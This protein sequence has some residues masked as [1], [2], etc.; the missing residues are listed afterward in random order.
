MFVGDG[1]T[2]AKELADNKEYFIPIH[3]G[4]GNNSVVIGNT[5]SQALGDNSY[6]AGGEV[7]AGTRGY[8]WE[9]IDLENRKIYLCQNQVVTTPVI[10]AGASYSFT[11]DYAIGDKLAIVNNNKYFPEAVITSIENNIITYE[12]DIGFTQI[13]AVDTDT[14]D[15]DDY[16]IYV[17]AKPA[18]EADIAPE[19]R[20]SKEIKRNA[21]AEGYLSNAQGNASHAEGTFSTAYGDHAHSEGYNTQAAWAAHS[22]GYTTHAKGFYSH[23]EGRQTETANGAE[24][25]H[26][27]G[28]AVK[29]SGYAAHGEGIGK[30]TGSTI[31]DYSEA[32]GRGSHVE[33]IYNKALASAAHVEGTNNVGSGP[34]SH[35][36]GA[37][38]TN[39]G[40]TTHVE[41][42]ENTVSTNQAHAEGKGNTLSGDAHYSHVEGQNNDITARIA[43]A[44]GYDNTISGQKAH[45]EG[46]S[47]TVSGV[48]AH[49]EGK[50]NSTVASY[51][52]VEGSSNKIEAGKIGSTNSHVEGES[53]TLTGGLASHI[54]GKNNKII[55]RTGE[56]GY[57]GSQCHI[58]G[59]GNTIE[60]DASTE[61][62]VEGRGNKAAAAQAHA[63]GKD[64]I[65][66]GAQSHAGGLGTRA[67]TTAQTAIGKYNIIDED[68]L[69]IVGKGSSNENRS[70][71][72]IIDKNGNAWFNGEV[73]VGGDGL[74]ETGCTPLVKS[75]E[76]EMYAKK[77][78]NTD[79]ANYDTIY[80]A[81]AYTDKR[82]Q[83]ELQGVDHSD[84]LTIAYGEGSVVDGEN[85]RAA[86]Y[87]ATA[88]GENTQAEG[89]H[90]YAGCRG[91]YWKAIDLDNKKI[92][93][94][95][96]QTTPLI[97][98]SIVIINDDLDIIG[99]SDD[100][101]SF[102]VTYYDDGSNKPLNNPSIINIAGIAYVI[103][104]E[105]LSSS[106]ISFSN[107]SATLSY[108]GY[109]ESTHCHS[110]TANMNF[111]TLSGSTGYIESVVGCYGDLVDEVPSTDYTDT[112][113][114]PDYVIGDEIAI[115]NNNKYFPG[116]TISAIEN[117]VITYDGEI[118]FDKINEVDSEN[119]DIDDYCIYVIAKPAPEEDIEPANRIC[120]SVKRDSHAEGCLSNAQGNASHAEGSATVAYGDH[121][122]AE[123]HDTRAAW[124]A[125][126]EGSGT[127][128]SGFRSHA[129]GTDT[130][131]S[132]PSSHAEGT[133]SQ[134]TNYHAHAE[135]LRTVASG[136]EAHSEGKQTTASG[137]GA[138]SEGYAT[139]AKGTYSHAE[140][141][142]T[143]ALADRT[144]SEG[145]MTIA[146]ADQSH[147][148]GLRSETAGSGAHAEGVD[149][150]YAVGRGSHAEGLGSQNNISY[151]Y[152]SGTTVT[153][154]TLATS[155]ASVRPQAASQASHT[156]GY[157]TYATGEGAHAEGKKTYVSGQAA[158]G[159]GLNTSTIGEASHAE[160]RNTKANGVAAHVE[161]NGTS[162][163][164]SVTYNGAAIGIAAHAEGNATQALGE[165]AHSEGRYTLAKGYNAHAEGCI[166]KATEN[167]T[168]AEGYDTTASGWGSHAENNATTSSG[169]SSHAEGYKTTAQG[170]YSHTEGQET[171]ASGAAAHAGGKGTKA[172]ATA[173][174]AI[175][176]YNAENN[177]ALFIVGN[178]SSDADRKNAFE[179][180]AD[181]GHSKD[182]VVLADV[183]ELDS[184]FT[185]TI[186]QLIRQTGETN[187]AESWGTFSQSVIEIGEKLSKAS[188]LGDNFLLHEWEV[189]D[190][191]PVAPKFNQSYTLV[192]SNSNDRPWSW[193]RAMMNVHFD[194]EFDDEINT[195]VG[196][197]DA[198]TYIRT[199][200][201]RYEDG[202]T[203]EIENLTRNSAMDQV[204]RN[205]KTIRYTS[206]DKAMSCSYDT[207]GGGAG[208]EYIPPHDP[209]PIAS[210]NKLGSVK[211]D[212]DTI[213]ITENGVISVASEYHLPKAT[214]EMNGNI[215]Q[216]VNGEW[217]STPMNKL[218]A[219]LPIYINPGYELPVTFYDLAT[220]ATTDEAE[221]TTGGFTYYEEKL[222]ELFPIQLSRSYNAQAQISIEPSLAKFSDIY[223]E[224]K[225]LT[226]KSVQ[227][228]ETVD[229]SGWD[230]NGLS[231]ATLSLKLGED[232]VEFSFAHRYDQTDISDAYRIKYNNYIGEYNILGDGAF[233][234][235]VEAD[236][237]ETST[238]PPVTIEN[239]GQFLQVVNGA[240][241][242]V[243]VG[244]AEEVLF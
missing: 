147:A 7:V 235:R 243:T 242:A 65:A 133:L 67:T 192:F 189:V 153:D 91:Y 195:T 197:F 76:L 157:T 200:I 119:Y 28:R 162:T 36:E 51:S 107:G 24:G 244:Q 78:S 206:T 57:G 55:G 108:I 212:D 69:F 185:G 68:A 71:A 99:V 64:T 183:W 213:K 199:I 59:F 20:I 47:N 193:R 101:R 4:E 175:G 155:V 178:G 198:I 62:H 127:T 174:T 16:C 74:N 182:V 100:N 110:Y 61:A 139:E 232:N 124:A 135:G 27:E 88:I 93:L 43:H 230:E 240:W 12:G 210:T 152:L 143:Q 105:T 166:T 54:E 209:T 167:H 126:S 223:Y 56:T 140:G 40:H 236:S 170:N 30:I 123:G 130:I 145:Y 72:H 196:F 39:S 227:A 238:L 6:A 34:Q 184:G 41:G 224:S 202:T 33:G 225:L 52:H 22:E 38:N 2:T 109:D 226:L 66:S 159:E 180:Y 15:I 141:A 102:T 172:T 176:K 92:Y 221:P 151:T 48:G 146:N 177:D 234:H 122:H 84:M 87:Y 186:D 191:N 37:K 96:E 231:W 217:K 214:E 26:A 45:V 111:G 219:E 120:K 53:N 1:T 42:E 81:K 118:G 179:V 137:E 73:Y 115:V 207:S 188:H 18:P 129:E 156:E 19:E 80:G 205:V 228:L 79:P 237:T 181:G 82:I 106:E 17:I 204:M 160:G 203:I 208:I 164:N 25:A 148:E 216:V 14:Y 116:A 142:S 11:P 134:S 161:G 85:G 144:H 86:G 239:N 128:A 50:G 46:E 89:R 171:L 165:G 8:Y 229:E 77:G 136:L 114:T 201:L 194:Y 190:G 98:S 5:N 29:V 60:G 31:E 32:T 3:K 44:E 94:S 158:H 138:H 154:Q 49:A 149:G 233:T 187:D 121:A 13:N 211:I 103:D 90:A 150:T 125:H 83:E 70:N 132:G 220:R 95:K 10:G 168:H 169:N 23:T 215:L 35:T 58:E 131:S 173:Q 113:F 97:V 222:F 112:S 163:W 104:L 218:G 75:N 9:A 63:E 21:Y 117:S 241:A